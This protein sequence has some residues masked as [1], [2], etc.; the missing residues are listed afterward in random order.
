[1]LVNGWEH[2]SDGGR[3]LIHVVPGHRSGARDHVGQGGEE[4]HV[5]NLVVVVDMVVMMLP[6]RL[7]RKLVGL[8]ARRVA[9][10]AAA[11]ADQ[12][13]VQVVVHVCLFCGRSVRLGG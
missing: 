7:R 2:L 10:A 6:G 9:A 13:G 12:G 4:G 8:I 5:V 3:A 1:M 11:I